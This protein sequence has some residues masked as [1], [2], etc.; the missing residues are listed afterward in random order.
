M[1]KRRQD[2]RRSCSRYCSSAACSCFALGVIGEY[3]G[4]AYL[5]INH[6]PQFAIRE[7][8]GCTSTKI[9]ATDVE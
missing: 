8:I 2:G 4:R 1:P 6:K 5:K 9:G 7:T 3:L